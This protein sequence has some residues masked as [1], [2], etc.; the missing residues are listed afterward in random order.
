[1]EAQISNSGVGCKS[2]WLPL[3]RQ[4][5]SANEV[6]GARPLHRAAE[7]VRHGKWQQK[8][9]PRPIN[10][11]LPLSVQR[12]MGLK[13]QNNFKEIGINYM[14]TNEYT[15]GKDQLLSMCKFW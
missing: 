6:Q 1:M 8:E 15:I 5:I 4:A 7:V 14:K 9:D 10:I 3:P 11:C 2:S 13:D 12:F